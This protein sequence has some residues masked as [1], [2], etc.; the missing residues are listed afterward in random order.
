MKD[1]IDSA[2]VDL[3]DDTKRG[4]GRPI[5]GK[6]K[7]NAERMREYRLRKSK[8]Q[9]VISP[10]PYSLS[11][12]QLIVHAFKYY[13]LSILG[14]D[15]FEGKFDGILL[16]IRLLFGYRSREYKIVCYLDSRL[17]RAKKKTMTN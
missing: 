2:T 17:K 1:T 7:S 3:F 16:S 12:R 14:S 13:S 8:Q 6:A 11:S 4:R 9:P 10:V 15:Y 5:T